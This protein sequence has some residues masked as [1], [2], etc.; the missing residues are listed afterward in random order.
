MES[1]FIKKLVPL[2]LTARQFGVLQYP[3]GHPKELE[4]AREKTSKL[5]NALVKKAYWLK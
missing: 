5:V 1:R 2:E 4:R 3:E